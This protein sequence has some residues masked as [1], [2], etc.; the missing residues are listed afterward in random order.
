MSTHLPSVN[1]DVL[2]RYE[3]AH[4]LFVALERSSHVD[5]RRRHPFAADL[6]GRADAILPQLRPAGGSI[7]SREHAK[8][9]PEGQCDPFEFR[10][11][12]G[13]SVRVPTGRREPGAFVGKPESEC[14]RRRVRVGIHQ[15][16]MAVHACERSGELDGHRG[17]PRRARRPPHRHHGRVGCRDPRRHGG[18][19]PSSCQDVARRRRRRG[20]PREPEREGQPSGDLPLPDRHDPHSGQIAGRHE[21]PGERVVACWDE[22]QLRAGPDRRIGIGRRDGGRGGGKRPHVH[23]DGAQFTRKACAV[24]LVKGDDRDGH[25]PAPPGTIEI[26]APSATAPSVAETSALATTSSTDAAPA[27]SGD[28]SR[29]TRTTVASATRMRGASNRV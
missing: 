23:S 14:D 6:Q 29:S 13:A 3:V 11:I 12:E 22:Q 17:A 27:A 5:D 18:R 28:V 8:P 4:D 19:G 7:D 10:G 1:S 15:R 9:T 21:L 20:R 2:R 25:C 24:R 16:R 26:A